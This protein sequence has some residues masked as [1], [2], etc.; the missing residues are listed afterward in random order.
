LIIDLQ[1]C[2]KFIG[3]G[4]ITPVC[5][6]EL[7]LT[8]QS[9]IHQTSIFSQKPNRTS[10]EKL[11]K[12]RL[13]EAEAN[14]KDNHTKT[15]GSMKLTTYDSIESKPRITSATFPKIKQ[16]SHHTFHP[17]NTKQRSIQETKPQNVLK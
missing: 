5:G 9:L 17:S 2:F 16:N 1:V 7:N 3:S 4:Q 6:E 13:S 14:K 15:K 8:D 10:H 12:S 11:S